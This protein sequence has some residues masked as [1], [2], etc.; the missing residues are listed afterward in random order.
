MAVG[1]EPALQ[2]GGEL[3]RGLLE[4]LPRCHP[5][6]LATHNGVVAIREPV[7]DLYAELGV[8]R[9]A[10]RDEIAAAFRARARDLHPD[11]HPGDIPAAERFKRV[12]MAYGVLSDP[13]RRARYDAGQLA[14]PLSPRAPAP[15]SGVAPP[16]PSPPPVPAG[17]LH[18]TRRAAR[19][20]VGGGVAVIVLGL[21][22]AVWVV[23]LQRHDADLRARGVAV[24]ATVVEV[25]GERRLEFTTRDGRTVRAVEQVKSGEEQPAVGARVAIH[26]ERNNP[27]SIVT[28]TSHTAR[29]ITLWIV[30]V[31]LFVGG[32]VLLVVGARRLSRD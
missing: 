22:T 7:D 14:A 24:V 11:V 18:L 2:R 4:V 25:G 15:T 27:T 20:A 28:D 10:S 23:S 19:W 5:S 31:K 26:Y 17:R 16:T 12:S 21:A 29:D 30:A 32:I 1:R 3:G 6:I 9:T 8:G 13:A